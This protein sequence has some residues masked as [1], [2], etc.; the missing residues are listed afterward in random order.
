MTKNKTIE[1]Y[2]NNYPKEVQKL[3][4]SI[5]ELINKITPE[6]EE[7]ISYGIPTFKLNG[8][9]LVHFAAYK[10]HLGFYPTP[11]AITAFEKELIKYKQAKGSVQFPLNEALPIKLIEK[12]VR[13]RVKEI[14]KKSLP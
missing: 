10:K 13:F 5:K 1:T 7:T 11:S 14:T 4:L 6:A 12:I 2:I 9:N 3:L 8:V